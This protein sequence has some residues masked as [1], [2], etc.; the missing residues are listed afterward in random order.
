M[1][2]LT[3]TVREKAQLAIEEFADRV[4]QP[5]D[6]SGRSLE[7]VELFL[8][9]ISAQSSTMEPETLSVIVELIG[10]YVLEVGHREFGGNYKWYEPGSQPV[11]IVGEPDTHVA[12]ISFEKVRGRLSGDE[13]DNISYFYNGFAIAAASSEPGMEAFFM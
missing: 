6:Y 7:A 10:C 13:E 9:E 11:L 1:S 4:P 5:M 8:R 3:E 12:I 2:D